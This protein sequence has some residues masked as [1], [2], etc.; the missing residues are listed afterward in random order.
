[1]NR[2]RIALVSL[3]L[4][5]VALGACSSATSS[6]APT[7]TT[8]AGP[9]A[10]QF[11]RTIL[12]ESQPA[13]APGQTLYLQRVAFGPHTQLALH[14]HEGLQ[15]S[16]ILSGELTYTVEQ[17]SAGLRRSSGS[18]S[19]IEAGTTVV[20]HPGDTVVEYVTTIHKGANNT[21]RVVDLII[22][23]LLTTGAPL[24]TPN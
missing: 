12:A 17:G 4:S 13:T 23:S 21:D 5:G 14:H 1:M 22:S 9:A 7:S 19:T 20:L 24:S 11:T 3:V 18:S 10:G 2:T 16:T 8:V 6:P 15:E